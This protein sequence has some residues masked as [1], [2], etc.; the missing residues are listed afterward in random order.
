MNHVV[1]GS[2]IVQLKNTPDSN[3]VG[4][5]ATGGVGSIELKED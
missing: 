4:H 3:R 1:D 2:T 5:P